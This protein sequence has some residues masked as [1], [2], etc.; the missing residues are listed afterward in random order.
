LFMGN[1]GKNPA[2][3]SRHF[4]ATP[5]SRF[6]FYKSAQFF[7]RAHNEA[8]TVSAMRVNNE[9]RSLVGIHPLRHQPTPSGSAEIISD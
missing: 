6:K 5:S 9:V 4:A 1:V 2:S 7:I 8:L 3:L